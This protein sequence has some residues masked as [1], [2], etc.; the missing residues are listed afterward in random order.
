MGYV[1]LP[2]SLSFAEKKF[3]VIGFD[4][5]NKK[6]DSLNSGKSYIHHIKTNRIQNCVNKNLLKASSDFRIISEIDCIIICV[7]TPL[8]D[9]REPDLSYITTTL[10][11]IAP[12][13]RKS[14]ILSLESTTYP[15]TTEEI[16]KP[17][18]ER[19][20]LTIGE[21]FFVVYSPERED[22]GN[23]NFNNKNTPKVMGGI[24][25]NCRHVGNFLYS[26]IFIDVVEVSSTRAAEM[27]KLLENIYR[28]V[29][30]GLVN[31]L[32]ELAEKLDIDI[33]EVIRAASTKPFGFTPY[34][35]GPGLGGHCLPIDPFF[36][37]WKAKQFNI[38]TRFIELAGE[39]NKAM[40]KYVVDKTND[41]LNQIGKPISNSRILI[42]GISYKKNIDDMRESPAVEI[43]EILRNKSADIQYSDPFFDKFPNIRK[44]YFNLNSVKLNEINLRSFDVTILITDHDS[45]DYYAIRN[46]SN[47]LIDTRGRFQPS[48]NI[49]RA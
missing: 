37:T 15:G 3:S 33:Y 10:N 30:I 38:N 7:P 22:P 18:V 17:I 26:Q 34:Y 16:I 36:L 9:H 25:N 48:E 29:N 14:Q 40:P 1:G 6:I 11:S 45:F 46:Y 12:Y 5:D 20:G 39:I 21:D 13:L 27:T 24:T 2:L 28:S 19:S 31:E 44:Y 47:L 8:N 42:L 32:K 41:A 23:D 49:I 35:P 4:I 43:M